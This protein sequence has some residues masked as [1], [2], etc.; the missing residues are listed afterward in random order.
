MPDGTI[1]ACCCYSVGAA[2]VSTTDGKSDERVG[3]IRLLTVLPAFAGLY[4]GRRLLQRV[5]RSLAPPPEAALGPHGRLNGCTRALCCVPQLRESMLTWAAQQGYAA[6]EVASF[7]SGMAASFSRPTR[8]VVLSKSLVGVAAPTSQKQI[9][10]AAVQSGL[11]SSGTTERILVNSFTEAVRGGVG[12]DRRERSPD[13]KGAG[14][15]QAR[16]VGSVD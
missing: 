2:A 4:V 5:E 9:G 16:D 12:E 11:P 7:P 1:L 14:L 3:A 6:G 15:R 10:G 8:L 13:V